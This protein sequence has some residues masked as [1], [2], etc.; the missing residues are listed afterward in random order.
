MSME[1][2]LAKVV[3]ENMPLAVKLQE[4]EAE[5]NVRQQPQPSTVNRISQL[6]RDSTS[7]TGTNPQPNRNAHNPIEAVA[8]AVAAATRLEELAV[9]TYTRLCGA[10]GLHPS[11]FQS[12]PGHTP[13]TTTVARIAT[14][15][16]DIE[17]RLAH[18]Q[19]LLERI[20][21]TFS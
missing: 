4:N 6:T 1:K 5:Q 2:E 12:P 14:M 10:E 13:E 11:P 16:R 15:V 3:M 8:R 21:S 17:A 18:S 19:D 9:A 20:R 7:G